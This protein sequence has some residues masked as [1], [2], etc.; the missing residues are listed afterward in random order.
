MIRP[1]SVFF[2]RYLLRSV[3]LKEIL[4]HFCHFLPHALL[5]VW[6]KV[7]IFIYQ[8]P[9]PLRE[10]EKLQCLQHSVCVCA[11][12]GCAAMLG[13]IMKRLKRDRRFLWLG[14]KHH[15]IYLNKPHC[16]FICTHTHVHT[17]SCTKNKGGVCTDRHKNVKIFAEAHS[18]AQK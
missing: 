7:F 8:S 12:G 3:K 9:L 16:S 2:L 15:L 5:L 11:S 1:R 17:H 6:R 4:C 10:K 18:I 13:V 14:I